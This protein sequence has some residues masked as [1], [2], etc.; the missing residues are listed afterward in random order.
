MK[1]YA[2]QNDNYM[3]WD[4]GSYDYDEAVK[5]AKKQIANGET[6]VKIAVINEETDYC[7]SEIMP[8][9]F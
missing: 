1:W 3:E 6:G 5:M 4:D 2:V 7:E 9:D 8:E